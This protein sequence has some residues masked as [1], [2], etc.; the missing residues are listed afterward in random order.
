MRPQRSEVDQ[1]DNLDLDLERIEFSYVLCHRYQHQLYSLARNLSWE[2]AF[3][4][5]APMSIIYW[6]F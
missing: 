5:F 4:I 1:E 2:L 3:D 6:Q